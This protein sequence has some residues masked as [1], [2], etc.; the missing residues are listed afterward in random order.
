MSPSLPLVQRI[1]G[2][3]WWRSCGAGSVRPQPVA[4]A[5]TLDALRPQSGGRQ[6]Q[7]DPAAGEFAAAHSM[8]A[9]RRHP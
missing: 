7:L 1:L 4:R 5:G 8:T 6:D 2:R 9:R 3:S